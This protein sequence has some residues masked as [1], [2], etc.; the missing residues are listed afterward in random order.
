MLKIG[1]GK[2]K[3]MTDSGSEVITNDDPDLR[4]KKAQF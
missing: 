1:L 2:V 4:I 3:E